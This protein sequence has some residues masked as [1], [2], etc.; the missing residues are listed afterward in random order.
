MMLVNYI[1]SFALVVLGI[2]CMVV[3]HNMI[4]TIIGMA[5]E[6]LEE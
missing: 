5:K 1:G 2:Y 4:K 3:K 6:H